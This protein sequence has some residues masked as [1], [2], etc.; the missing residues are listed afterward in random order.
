M[1]VYANTEALL[2]MYISQQKIVQNKVHWSLLALTQ[3]EFASMGT[4]KKTQ[5]K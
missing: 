1:H 2:F 3:W 4:L 5:R